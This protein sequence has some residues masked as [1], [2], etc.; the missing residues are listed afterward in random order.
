MRYAC[1]TRS[2]HVILF[3]NSHQHVH[4]ASYYATVFKVSSRAAESPES[5]VVRDDEREMISFDP[6]TS[7]SR[8]TRDNPRAFTGFPPDRL[9]QQRHF[10]ALSIKICFT[11]CQYINNNIG[12]FEEAR[13]FF[14][15]HTD[16]KRLVKKLSM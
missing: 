1:M 15:N 3:Y 10:T 16:V 5:S 9:R 13:A 8:K 14:S 6:G 11:G 12:Y 7:S 2:R 4:R